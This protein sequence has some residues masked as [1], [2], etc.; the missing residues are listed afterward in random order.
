M[1]VVERL[2]EL[3]GIGRHARIIRSLSRAVG[4]YDFDKALEVFDKLSRT[5]LE[6]KS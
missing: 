5:C 3:P 1:E 6:V 2:E 4:E